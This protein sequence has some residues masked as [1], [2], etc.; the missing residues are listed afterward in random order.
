MSLSDKELKEIA[1]LARINIDENSFPALKGRVRSNT[2]SF[3]KAKFG[4]YR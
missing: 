1:Y 2:E 3:R 4:Q